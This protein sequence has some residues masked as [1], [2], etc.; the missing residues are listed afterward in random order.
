MAS[1]IVSS[2]SKCDTR[3]FCRV[4][5]VTNRLKIL[6]FVHDLDFKTRV[7]KWNFSARPQSYIFN[8]ILGGALIYFGS[9][10]V[11]PLLGRLMRLIGIVVCSLVIIVISEALW[12]SIFESFALEIL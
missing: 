4:F 5:E 11:D 3:Q 10:I 1:F 2:I 6:S 9:M 12:R 7:G 8:V